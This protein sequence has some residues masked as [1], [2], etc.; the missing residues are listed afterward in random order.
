MGGARRS[1]ARAFT[2]AALGILAVSGAVP[3]LVPA[4]E[5]RAAQRPVTFTEDLAPVIFEYCAPCHHPGGSATTSFLT[6]ADAR[7]RGRQLAAVTASRAMPPWQPEHGFASFAGERRLSD[8]QVA[9]FQ[10]WVTDGLPEGNPAL[11]PAAPTWSDGWQLGAPDLVLTMPAYTL[12]AGG[13]D[14]FRSFVIP[15]P[16]DRVRYI[17]AWELRPGNPRVV[18]HATMQ[19]DPTRMSR[20]FESENGEPG[21]EGIVALS[22][23][24]P[25]GFF[26]DWAPGHRP[27]QAVN[28]TAWPLPPASDVVLMLHLRPSGKEETVQ[29]SVGLYF[30]D[31]PP[32][33]VPVM[34]RLA[35]EHIDIPPGERRYELSDSFTLPVDV[36]VFTVQPHAHYLAREMRGTARLPNGTAQPLIFI[37]AW[38]FDWQDVYH[39]AS[40][41]VLPAGTVLDMHYTYDNSADNPRNP[42]TPPRRVIY[43]QQTSDEMAELWLQVLPHSPADRD[44][45]ARAVRAKEL[46]D[47]IDGR[48][49]MLAADPA[50]VVLH[51]DLALLYAEVGD[52][53]GTLREF[54]ESARLRPNSAPA[55]YNL[56]LALSEA[57]RGAEAR[58]Y[59]EKAIA[60]DP[61]YTRAHVELARL[62]DG[63]GDLSGAARHYREALRS[64]PSEDP[65]LEF[66]AALALSKSG[67]PHEGALVLRPAL[68]ARPDWAEAQAALA[69]MLAVAPESSPSEHAE[70]LA[71]AARLARA[72]EQ[73]PDVASLDILATAMAANGQFDDAIRTGEQALALATA[74]SDLGEIQALRSRLELFRQRVPYQMRP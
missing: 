54:G 26:L 50:N 31:V 53:A 38:N 48:L 21:Y 17:K 12:R 23:R 18:H 46:P 52:A 39:Y 7:Q 16:V 57:G 13:R 59:F 64:S 73:H 1:P 2:V 37:K 9:M 68:M 56:G 14:M 4:L 5:G 60:I 22:A 62:L 40:P 34:V 3:L 27:A 11:L 42:S 61:G 8:D 49:M 63:V 36:D 6:Y 72:A 65:G 20:R 10:D 45:L 32:T 43:G 69:W 19:I 24:T 33:K 58:A 30:S 51:D 41:L 47:E 44:V 70:A 55:S 71:I 15:V 29:A 35:R 66:A 28:G 25:D 67:S 74:G